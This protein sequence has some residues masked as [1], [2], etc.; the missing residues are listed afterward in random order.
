MSQSSLLVK[1]IKSIKFIVSTYKKTVRGQLSFGG[2]D[3]QI[4]WNAL[5]L[6]FELFRRLSSE[7]ANTYHF[8]FPANL[9][10]NIQTWVEEHQLGIKSN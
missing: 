9:F 4:I 5:T 3:Q 2:Y 10:S 7:V 6:S 1:Y 8:T